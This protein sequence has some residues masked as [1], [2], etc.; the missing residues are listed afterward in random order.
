MKC[1]KDDKIF[2]DDS[3]ILS[4]H[5]TNDLKVHIKKNF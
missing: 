3:C 5:D 2:V 1:H 4:N